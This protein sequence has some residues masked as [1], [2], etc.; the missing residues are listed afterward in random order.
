MI[1]IIAKEVAAVRPAGDLANENRVFRFIS[2]APFP[3]DSA[4]IQAERPS[5]EEIGV[6]P[7][8]RCFPSLVRQF[9]PG[10]ALFL[11]HRG[12]VGNSPEVFR[13]FKGW[14]KTGSAGTSFLLAGG[15]RG[16]TW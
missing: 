16:R 12:A 7:R 6:F 14:R 4:R 13:P 8:W 3:E 2:P 11:P 9:L 15:Y 1:A 5:E 10:K